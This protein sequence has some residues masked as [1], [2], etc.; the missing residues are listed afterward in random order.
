L[1][2]KAFHAPG[3]LFLQGSP[4]LREYKTRYLIGVKFGLA[5]VS[6]AKG[7]D[8]IPKGTNSASINNS[9]D[10]YKRRSFYR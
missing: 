1:I 8:A 5:V 2:S 9:F 4:E 10:S 7:N 3:G 6:F